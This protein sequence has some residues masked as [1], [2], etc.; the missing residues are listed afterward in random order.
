MSLQGEIV[1][2]FSGTY[3][4]VSET[5][6]ID[7][8]FFFL[9]PPLFFKKRG[10]ILFCTRRSVGRSVLV[11]QVISAHYHLTPLLEMLDRTI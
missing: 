7:A 6:T 9:P 10:G 2:P 1:I 4:Y 8:I 5:V 11:D 3:T